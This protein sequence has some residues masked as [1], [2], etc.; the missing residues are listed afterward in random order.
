[1]FDNL[2]LFID[3]EWIKEGRRT[4]DLIDPATEAVLGQV[5]HATAED[6]D[7]AAKAAHRAFLTWKNV[8]A[9]ERARIISGAAALMRARLDAIAWNLTLE[10]GK[11]I[12]EARTEVMFAADILDWY[13]EEGKRAYGRQIPSRLPGAM[14]VVLKEPVGPCASFAAWNV[15]ATTP[16][17][18]IGGALAAG[19][20]LV[21][22]PSEE[23]PAT[24]LAIAKAFEDAGL[25]AGV[26]NIVFG[27]PAE[28]SSQLIAT[29]EIR[30][31]SFTGSTEVGKHLARLAADRVLRITLELGGHAP[32]IVAEDADVEK[33]AKSVATNKY[34]NAGQICISPSRFFV[35]DRVHDSFVRHFTEISAALQVKPGIDEDSDIGALANKRRLDAMEAFVEDATSKG[36]TIE[37]GGRRLGNLGFFFPPTVLSDVPDTASAMTEEI[38]GPV[39]PIQRFDTLDGVIEKAN[40]L[41]YGLAAY[42][43]TSSQKTAAEISSRIETGMLGINH[44]VVFTPETPFGGVKESGYGSEGGIEGLE[45]YLT[46]KLVSQLAW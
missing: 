1:M 29:A 13:A 5:P 27:V 38:F 33:A 21:L 30:K 11:P 2:S 41:P 31:V 18:K 34:R 8:S 26:L 17:R 24:A 20:T 28:I 39:V 16:C 3:G 7:R 43:Y 6:L 37:C 36:A 25:P 23:T 15:P 12:R 10:S 45:A 22:K 46:P 35:H 44:T 4:E 19:C 40:A 9:L 32:V 14:Q 42:A